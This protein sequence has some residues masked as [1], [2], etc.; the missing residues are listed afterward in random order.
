MRIIYNPTMIH[1]WTFNSPTVARYAIEFFEEAMPAP[2]PIAASSQ[3]ASLKTAFSVVGAVGLFVFF[4][5]F[6]LVCLRARPFAVLAAAGPIGPQET[7]RRGKAW[8]WLGMGA[9]AL[10]AA[11]TFPL[12][13]VVGAL[14]MSDFFNQHQAAVFGLWSLVTGLF[15]WFVLWLTYRKYAK[16]HGLSLREQG[17][18]LSRDK[19]V[20]TILLGVLA[21]VATYGIVFLVD[22]L[23]HTDFHVW[24]LF[25]INAFEADKL[26]LVAQFL[27]FF[28]FFYAVN[29]VAVNVFNYVRIGKH[30]WVNTALMAV[31][32][33]LGVALLYVWVYS[34]FLTSGNTPTDAFMWGLSSWI[35][36]LLGM[37]VILPLAVVVSRIVYK[38]TRNPYL[39]AV[40]WSILV[41]AMICT[42]N[43][44]EL[45]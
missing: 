13:W 21:A 35:N 26:V 4:I 12:M 43:L 34:V 45:F 25:G 1:N 29:S 33:V 19:V 32:N 14:V 39:P 17:V 22:Y 28:L 7:T 23:F 38:A 27:P 3:I 11:I 40:G 16:A 6:I 42:R 9:S 5:N 2:N 30:E 18:Y 8:L 20:P 36:W 10:F 31:F 15:T 41:T 24:L 37:L 44:T